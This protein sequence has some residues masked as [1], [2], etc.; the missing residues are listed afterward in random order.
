MLLAKSNFAALNLLVL[1][2]VSSTTIL[3]VFKI[4]KWISV[5]RSTPFKLH[6]NNNIWGLAFKIKAR[7]KINFEGTLQSFKVQKK[8]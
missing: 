2:V 1:N 6:N 8:W 4:P 7:K 5:W 3:L